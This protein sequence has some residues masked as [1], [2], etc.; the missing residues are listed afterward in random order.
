MPTSMEDFLFDLRGYIVLKGALS[1]EQVQHINARADELLETEP[2]DDGWIGNVQ[3]HGYS[4]VD[5]I[6]LQ[7]IVEGGAPFEELIDNPNWIE[8]ARRFIG[9]YDGL[10]ID[11]CFLNVRGAGEGLYLH[12][13]AWKRRQRTQFRYH[14]GEFR[15]GMVNM[16]TAL[17]DIGEDDGAT[18]VVPGTHKSNIQH[19]EVRWPVLD[20]T[21]QP[22]KNVEGMIEVHLAAGD[23]LLFVDSL[24]HGA[25]TR[26]NPGE[27]RILVY[28]YGP[29]WGRTRLGYEYSQEFLERLSPAQRKIMQPVAPRRRRAM[30]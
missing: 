11:E 20:E 6:N 28:R 19:P 26:A 22:A 12:S 5:G 15:C 14:N 16:L 27:R 3:R 23:T 29:D 18:T 4:A 21:E 24:C 13:G 30:L 1:K 9:E 2:D 25:V 10:F 17:T 8:H 7:N